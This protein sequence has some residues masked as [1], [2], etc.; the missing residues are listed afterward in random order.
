MEVADMN[1]SSSAVELEGAA[2]EAFAGLVDYL[3]DYKDCADCMSETEKLKNFEDV[4]DYLDTLSNGGF[5]VTYARRDP[6]C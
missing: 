4:R 1:S 3:R 2:A 6:N 5:S